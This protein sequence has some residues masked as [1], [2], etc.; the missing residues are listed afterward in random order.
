MEKK[1]LEKD[2]QRDVC[3]W[4]DRMGFYFWRSNN[5][6][7]FGKNNGGKMTFRALP[8]YT[9]RG[10]PDIMVILHGKF[11]GVEIKQPSTKLSEH[12]VAFQSFIEKA[13]A[14][15]YV[16]RSVE[17]IKNVMATCVAEMAKS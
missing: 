9:P 7:V 13:G 1:T 5:I 17:D 2:I 3:E 14:R 4:L 10:L 16:V 12:Q 15:Y 11:I 8:K 6:P